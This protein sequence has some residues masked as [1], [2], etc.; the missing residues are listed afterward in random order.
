MNYILVENRQIIHL[1]PITWRQRFI[2]SELDDLEVDYQVMPVESGYIKI[3]DNFEIIP[4]ADTVN[5]DFNPIYEELSGPFWAYSDTSVSNEYIVIQRNIDH[6]KSTLIQIAANER[7]RKENLGTK[8]VVQGQEVSIDT[9]RSNRNTL[10]QSF[11][12]MTDTDTLQWK[13]PEGWLTLSYSD[14]ELVVKASAAYIQAQFDWEKSII[15]SITN[16]SDVD[17]LKEIVI[18]ETAPGLI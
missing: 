11:L 4:I 1:G 8:A 10:A 9:L 15:D 2:Q 16:A 6:V 13:F 3:N 17:T 5:P 7:Y 14:A 18:V 12:L